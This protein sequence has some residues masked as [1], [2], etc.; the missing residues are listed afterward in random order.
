MQVAP[1]QVTPGE[2]FQIFYFVRNHTDANQYYIQATIYD[3]ADG[4]ALLTVPLT[5][6]PI[7]ARLFTATV[8]APGDQAGYGRNIVAISTVCTDSGMSVKSE[9]YEETEQYFLVKA[10]TFGGGGGGV[11]YR[12]I[13]E[14]LDE[15]LEKA[16][17]SLPKPEKA[18]TPKEADLSFVERL[19]GAIEALQREVNRIPKETADTDPLMAEVLATQRMLETRPQFERTDLS[20][21][22]ELMQNTL[23]LLE[24]TAKELKLGDAQVLQTLD[25]ALKTA[26]QEITAAISAKVEETIQGQEFTMPIAMTVRNSKKQAEGQPDPIAGVRSLMS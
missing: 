7:N 16:L 22:A 5:Q 17:K 6:S 19:F 24:R 8:N 25:S 26:S 10:P 1:Q 15:R 18:P 2:N 4:T 13:G 21:L 9:N 3:V 12:I 23:T 20:S 11:D 14:M